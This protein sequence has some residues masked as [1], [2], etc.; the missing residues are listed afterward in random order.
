MTKTSLTK[1]L[2]VA[3]LLAVGAMAT[4]CTV[5]DAPADETPA[6][7]SEALSA[8]VKTAYEFF[9]AKGLKNYQAAGIVGNLMQESNVDPTIYQ[10]GGGPGRGIAQW[11]AGDRWDSAHHDNAVWY[12]G[13]RGES[14]W[15]LNLQLEFIWY[16]L[17]NFGY[18]FNSLKASSN[19]SQATYAFMAYYE[20]CGQCEQGQR[21]AYAQEVLNA[22]G[23]SSPAPSG[24]GGDCVAGGLYC[25][26][27]KVSGDSNTLYRCDGG[28]AISVQQHCSAGC[29]VNAG[30]DDSCKSG[31]SPPPPPPSG[32]TCVAG[33]LYCGGD[34]L[35]GDSHS[36]YRCN[37]PGAPT[38]L[39][40]CS[41][42]C[43]VI[44]GHDDAC[45]GSGGCYAGGLYC[46][47]D[48]VTGDP[49]T[50]YK[51]TGG[52]SGVVVSQCAKGCAVVS[53]AND[54]CN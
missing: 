38:D 44:A 19:L 20:I 5:G 23:S 22:Y 40:H 14:P 11:S 4:N 45:R 13:T 15:S 46:G 42:G 51:C 37:G 39:G 36:L 28:G 49:S 43:E 18:G 30:R 47:G 2:G 33:G 1:T 48:K 3:L 16:E 21:D 34:K 25:G 7:D 10:Y 53:G 17:N 52:S 31:G 26:G 8:N 35:S 9:V 6:N 29:S 41:D 12:A 50:L 27:D 24:P 54:R 32:G